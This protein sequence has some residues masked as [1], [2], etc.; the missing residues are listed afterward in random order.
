MIESRS[1]CSCLE[2][3]CSTMPRHGGFCARN[4]HA[5]PTIPTIR[6]A[7]IAGRCQAASACR[8]LDDDALITA[9]IVTAR[10]QAEHRTGRALVCR[11]SGGWGWIGSG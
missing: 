5:N 6:R 3:D 7:V 9:L 4:T 10:Q 8:F 1:S 11:S 2:N